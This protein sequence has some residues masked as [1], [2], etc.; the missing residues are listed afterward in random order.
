[1]VTPRLRPPVGRATGR[2]LLTHTSGL[3]YWFLNPDLLRYH[4]V[5]G[6][7]DVMSG[8]LEGLRSAAGRR[9][10]GPLGIRCQHRLAR[11]G[12]RGRQREG[13]RGLLSGASL[14]AA[15]NGRC[16]LPS[17]RGT[18]GTHDSSA[19]QDARRRP[20]PA[21]ARVARAGICSRAV[22]GACATGPDYM[23]FMRALLRG[24]ELDGE[25]VLRPETSNWRSTTTST[26]RRY[27]TVCTRR[28]PSSQTTYPCCRSP[29][30]WGLGFHLLLEDVPGM[31]RAGAG[32]WSG[33][34]NCYYWIDRA[35][36]AATHAHAGSPLLRRADSGGRRSL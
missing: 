25:R 12:H 33:L 36:F 4:Q 21:V 26:A 31:R 9:S 28:S 15:G 35:A 1:M 23:R 29:Q 24:G 2:H 34:F 27:R 30:G 3:G 18:G 32:D 19:L 10:R 11:A 6:A 17:G 14:R 20:R 13:S 5:T 16:D 7:P 22:V 8:K